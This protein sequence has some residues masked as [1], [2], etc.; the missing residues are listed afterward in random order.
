[1]QSDTILVEIPAFNIIDSD[2][3]ISKKTETWFL[4]FQDSIPIARTTIT[5]TSSK[6]VIVYILRMRMYRYPFKTTYI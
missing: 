4:F 3:L 5:S 1:M 6:S 2:W